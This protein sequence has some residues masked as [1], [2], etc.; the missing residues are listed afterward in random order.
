VSRE[1]LLRLILEQIHESF[2]S[3]D[4]ISPDRSAADVRAAETSTEKQA[5]PNGRPAEGFANVT[6][7]NLRY[8]RHYGRYR[9]R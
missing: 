2:R 8:R 7:A 6:F 3:V 1:K 5:S 4:R 9:R